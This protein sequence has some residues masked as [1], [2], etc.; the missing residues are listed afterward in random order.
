MGDLSCGIAIALQRRAACSASAATRGWTSLS[1]TRGSG[2]VPRRT[3]LRHR[4]QLQLQA[5][6]FRPVKSAELVAIGVANVGQIHG[7]VT[8]FA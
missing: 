1:L 3:Q 4:I 8:S 5:N 7:A 2:I 6:L